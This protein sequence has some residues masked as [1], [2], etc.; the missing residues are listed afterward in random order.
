VKSAALATAAL[1]ALAFVSAPA[2]A[3]EQNSRFTRNAGQGDAGAVLQSWARC[4]ADIDSKWSQRLLDTVPT[5][6]LEEKV[7]DQRSNQS[8]R[9][10]GEDRLIMDGKQLS[11]SLANG[12]GSLARALAVKAL[13]DGQQP[14]PGAATAWLTSKV[15]ADPTPAALNKGV[16]IGHDLAAC[17]ADQHWPLARDT[18]VAATAKEDAGAV[19]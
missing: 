7:F 3:Q 6:A 12:R 15:A 4:M 18:V 16:L 13:K 17:L 10:L 11:F 8:D 2:A 14:A 1:S 5:S 19:Q 9:G